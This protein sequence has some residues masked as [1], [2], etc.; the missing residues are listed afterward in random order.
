MTARLWISRWMIPAAI[1]VA[2]T[3]A[4]TAIAQQRPA[5]PVVSAYAELADRTL[6]ADVVIVGKVDR[7]DRVSDRKAT[8]L[9]PGDRRYL[10]RVKVERAL[11]APGAVPA[12]VPFLWDARGTERPDLLTRDVIA[13]LKRE[14]LAD[15]RLTRADGL[16]AG[17]ARVEQTVRAIITEAQSAVLARRRV[18]G[19]S[20][21]NWSPGTVAGESETQFFLKTERGGPVSLTVLSRPGRPA[22]VRAAFSDAIDEAARVVMPNTLPWYYLSCGLPPALPAAALAGQ[23]PEAVAAAQRDYRAALAAIGPCGLQPRQPQ[24]EA[25]STDTPASG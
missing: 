22:E 21:F 12:S 23:T 13:F 8:G 7:V 4:A 1:A 6:G 24:K 14:S 9:A 20:S 3:T 18:T 2:V 15:Y 10:V 11:K 25:S 5:P 16:I 17:G 19:I